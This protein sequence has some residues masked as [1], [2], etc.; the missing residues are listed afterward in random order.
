MSCVGVTQFPCSNV[1]QTAKDGDKH[2]GVVFEAQFL[3]HMGEDFRRVEVRSGRTFHQSFGGGHEKG[4]RNSL[5]RNVPDRKKQLIVV[6]HEE[7]IKISAYFLGR[8][9]R[10]ENIEFAPFRKGRESLRQKTHLDCAGDLQF[11]LVS[12]LG[13]GCFGKVCDIFLQG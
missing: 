5:A 1:Q 3:I 11:A 10:G 4:C 2:H 12:F 8:D 6:Q 7:V 13:G 9:Q